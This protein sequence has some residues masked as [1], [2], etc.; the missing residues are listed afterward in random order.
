MQTVDDV[1]QREASLRDRVPAPH[2]EQFD[3]LLREARFTYRIRDER[4]YFN[5][6]WSAGIAR[7]A[8]LEA[9]RRLVAQ[10]RLHDAQ[11][12]VELTPDELA[13]VLA[14]APPDADNAA[15]ARYRTA[16]HRRRAAFLAARP[17]RASDVYRPTPREPSARLGMSS[18][19]VRPRATQ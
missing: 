2:R 15:L 8:I 14:A 4:T 17:D 10:K 6:M 3:E 13:S 7:R 5:D 16:H 19:N 11:H 18:A 12:A 1:K 9:G